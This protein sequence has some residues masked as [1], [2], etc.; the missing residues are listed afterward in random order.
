LKI[1]VEM[2]ENSILGFLMKKAETDAAAVTDYLATVKNILTG[3]ANTGPMADLVKNLF[4]KN[5]SPDNTDT[6]FEIK[7]VSKSPPVPACDTCVHGRMSGNGFC[8][9]CTVRGGNESNYEKRVKPDPDNIVSHFA[10]GGEIPVKDPD[11]IEIQVAANADPIP[12]ETE[13]IP[14]SEPDAQPSD[15]Q[16]SQ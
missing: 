13:Q 12:V 10:I 11:P 8:P 1:T 6:D 2:D 4:T 16:D 15:S 14:E 7:P 3:A 5:L 9:T